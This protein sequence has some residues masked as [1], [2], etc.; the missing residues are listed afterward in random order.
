MLPNR[1]LA[2]LSDENDKLNLH[3]VE[4]KDDETFIVKNNKKD[5]LTL[6]EIEKKWRNIALVTEKNENEI[7]VNK[8]KFNWLYIL[9][10]FLLTTTLFSLNT[11]LQNKLFFFFP[12]LGILFSIIALQDLFGTKIE[13]MNN[14]CN[15]SSSTSCS[16]VIGSKKWKVFNYITFGDL[17]IIFFISQFFVLIISILIND[18]AS[19]FMLQEVLIICSIPIILLSLYFQKFI[20]K[21]WCPIC[22]I[23]ILITSSEL[24]Y[25]YSYITNIS[26][27]KFSI[28]LFLFVS[29]FIYLIWSLLKKVLIQNKDLKES[30]FKANRFVRNYE[31]FKSSLISKEKIKFPYTNISLGNKDSKL[32]INLITNPFCGH[33]KKTHQILDSIL[34]KHSDNIQIQ[35]IIRANLKNETEQEQSLYRTLIHIYTSQ[36]QDKFKNALNHWFENKEIDE[37]LNSF[38]VDEIDIDEIDEI[39]NVHYVWTSKNN[40]NYTPAIFINGYEYPKSYE[41]ENLTFFVNELIS[42]ADFN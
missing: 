21:K 23:I 32:T 41:R 22:L 17:S 6:L 2:L 15:L 34:D 42:D 9:A 16:S 24:L 31:N 35:I 8:N 4:K 27:T 7:T 20:E 30:Q 14:F 38:Q 18:V 36:G 11:N 39:Y 28:L 26:I 13:I 19:F 37:W 3:F 29:L 40:L 33:C 12:G 1:F 25:L 10:F 5:S